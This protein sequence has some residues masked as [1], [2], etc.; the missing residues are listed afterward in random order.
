MTST[1]PQFTWLNPTKV[2]FGPGRLSELST[3]IGEAAGA[4]AR[5]FLVTGRRNLRERGVLQQVVDSIGVTRVTL[6]DQVTPF[7]APQLVADALE[8]CRQSSSQVV[9]AIG[10]GSAIDVGK[11]VSILMTHEGSCQE[12][13]SGEKRIS[14]H[15]LPFIAV[16][17]TSGSSSEVTSGAAVWDW[18]ARRS[19]NLN[20]PEMFPDV[21]IVDPELAMS[22]P[23]ELA[24]LTG[25]DAFTSA[26]ES[27][28]SKEAQP[29]ADALDLQVIR[30][31]AAN[32]ERSCN[33]GDL[34][35]RSWCSLGAT[36]SGVAYSNSH[37][38]VCHAIGSPLT[39]FWEVAHGQAVGVTLPAMLKWT[40]PAISHKLPALWD[41]LGVQGLEEATGRIVQIM[42]NCGLKTNLTSLGVTTDGLET[43]VEHTRWDRVSALPTPLGHD[44][45]RGLLQDLM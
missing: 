18:A 36:M 5:V 3:V 22:M 42:E 19:I 8:A 23:K 31:F 30:L 13:L 25:M 4:Q 44:D 15:G 16:P 21:A 10:G 38:N 37:P 12:Y 33:D 7:P 24:A 2:I 28:W 14:H 20:H 9:V 45:L 40:A 35:S 41:A 29:V 11:I 17:T 1:L 43:L 34:E 27:Y 39:L 26:F 32:L 6:F